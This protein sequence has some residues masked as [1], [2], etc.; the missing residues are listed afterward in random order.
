MKVTKTDEHSYVGGWRGGP[1][2]Q[3][4][5]QKHGNSWEIDTPHGKVKIN[6]KW[7]ETYDE[8][9]NEAQIIMPKEFG[10]PDRY[11]LAVGSPGENAYQCLYTGIDY[12]HS[13][14]V[15]ESNL[16]GVL[17]R[18]LDEY[19]VV[20]C[21]DP[22][23]VWRGRF[24]VLGITDEIHYEEKLLGIESSDGRFYSDLRIAVGKTTIAIENGTNVYIYKLREE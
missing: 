20:H 9:W 15:D 24:S 5:V 13:I 7:G 6:H 4:F 21:R 3:V 22:K 19:S 17:V 16:Y 11:I 14:G 18:Y 1:S 10:E 8:K 23:E 12:S 2:H